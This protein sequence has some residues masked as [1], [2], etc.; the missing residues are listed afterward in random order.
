MLL[1]IDTCT[2]SVKRTKGKSMMRALYIL[3]L[4]K[5][6]ASGQIKL[7]DVKQSPQPC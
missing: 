1:Q 7:S 6:Q 2:L 4:A 5:W 3:H